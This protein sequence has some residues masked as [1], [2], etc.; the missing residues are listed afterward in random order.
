MSAAPDTDSIRGFLT[1]R[2]ARLGPREV[3][4]VA[5]RTPRRVPGLRREEVAMLAG[6]SVEYYTRIERGSLQGVSDA[7]LEAIARALQLDADERGYLFDLADAV[8][9]PGRVVPAPQAAVLRPSV[10]GV[11]AAITEAPAFVR[12]HR[13]DVLAANPLGRALYAQMYDG[14]AL[15]ADGTSVNT[16]RFIFL[17]PRARRF[18]AGWDSAAHNTVAILRAATGEHP[19]DAALTA[20][21]EDLSQRS[22]LFRELWSRHDVRHHYQGRK[23]YHHPVVGEIEL[24]Y[25]TMALAPDDGLSLAVY[26]ALPGSAGQEALRRLAQLVPAGAA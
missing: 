23:H 5:S 12:D 3:G 13:R 8:N 7:V 24:Q 20:L 4:L 19:R 11:L 1:S 22:A 26:P 2:R 17:D 16:A 9:A 15:G 25:E 6:V 14:P 10:R 18:Y 21:I